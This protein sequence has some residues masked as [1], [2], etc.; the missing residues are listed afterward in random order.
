MTRKKVVRILVNGKKNG[1][2]KDFVKEDE[3]M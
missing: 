2:S 3:Y 1:S